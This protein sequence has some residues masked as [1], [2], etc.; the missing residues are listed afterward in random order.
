MLITPATFDTTT[1]E[2]VSHVSAFT[3]AHPWGPWEPV[4]TGPVPGIELLDVRALPRDIIAKTGIYGPY[5][6]SRLTEWQS[7]SNTL[8]IVFIASFLDGKDGP[9]EHG[10]V[11]MY[12]AHL[13]CDT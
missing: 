6:I 5:L 1:M 2:W 8:R 12:E 11:H 10:Q 7:E 9:E 3:A 13:R 4:A